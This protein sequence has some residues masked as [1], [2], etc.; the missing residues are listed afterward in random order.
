MIFCPPFGVMFLICFNKYFAEK[1]FT[2]ESM[3]W[4]HTLRGLILVLAFILSFWLWPFLL[5]KRN[6]TENSTI[7]FTG[8]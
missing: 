7:V 1:R 8:F 2:T 4:V 6:E 5:P 3:D